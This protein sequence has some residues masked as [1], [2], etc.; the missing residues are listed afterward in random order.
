ME[1]IEPALASRFDPKRLEKGSWQVEEKH[2]GHRILFRAPE[3]IAW[4]R[5]GNE[6]ALPPHLMRSIA[7]LPQLI[8]DSEMV[9][10]SESGIGVSH[11]VSRIDKP[12]EYRLVV[13]DLLVDGERDLTAAGGDYSLVQRRYR[14]L[15]RVGSMLPYFSPSLDDG[16]VSISPV[17]AER[18]HSAEELAPI[19]DAMFEAGGEGIMIKEMS[20]SYRPGKRMLQWLKMKRVATAVGTLV[21]F[22][23]GLMGFHSVAVIED[24]KGRFVHVKAKDYD[25]LQRMAANAGQHIGRHVVFEYT[26]ITKYGAYREP[27]WDRFEDE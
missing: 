20:S 16:H 9:R 26:E 17:L 23:T 11:D 1:F 5:Q 24:S 3:G 10:R 6:R 14:L 13:F 15:E 12:E 2:D 27:R 25:W 19:R 18:V 22:Q 4:S 8:L 7:R 21:G